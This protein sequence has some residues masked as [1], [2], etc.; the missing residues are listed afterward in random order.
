LDFTDRL[1]AVAALY[2]G[3][4]NAPFPSRWR[5]ADVAEFDMIMLDADPSGCISVWLKRHGVLDDWRWN[6]LAE[7]E[8]QLLRVIPELDE[9]ARV[10]YQ[11]ILD[12]AVLVLEADYSSTST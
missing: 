7:C 4:T 12:M 8:Q 5:G 3:H 10:Y 1:A 9:Y 11:R 2:E 6:I